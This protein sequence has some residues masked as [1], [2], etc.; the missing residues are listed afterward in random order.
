[1]WRK[2]TNATTLPQVFVVA[3]VVADCGFAFSANLLKLSL[4]RLLHLVAMQQRVTCCATSLQV[5]AGVALV[6]HKQINTA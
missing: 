6:Q 5:V 3:N 4:L 2:E 1:V